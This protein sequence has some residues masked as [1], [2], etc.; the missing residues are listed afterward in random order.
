MLDL[1]GQ[2][3]CTASTL[4]FLACGFSSCMYNGQLSARCPGWHSDLSKRITHNKTPSTVKSTLDF[5]QS[6]TPSYALQL[7]PFLWHT[8]A[9]VK[10][11]TVFLFCSLFCI[12][13]VSCPFY[14]QVMTRYIS[15]PDNLKLMMNMLKEKSR[16]I[17]FEAFHVFKVQAMSS[18]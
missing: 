4:V 8:A 7:C 5:R 9:T 17:Q 12:P 14:F 1:C 18:F 2:L 11:I 3:P 16:N 13:I 6:V 10:P 15:N